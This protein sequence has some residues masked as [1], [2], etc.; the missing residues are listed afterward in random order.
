MI[1]LGLA[2]TLATHMG[3]QCVQLADLTAGGVAGVI[4][5]VA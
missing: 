3:G 2:R 1:R 5:A 4:R